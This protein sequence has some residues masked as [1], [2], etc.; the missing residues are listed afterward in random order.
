MALQLLQTSE[1]GGPAQ[2][3]AHTSPSYCPHSY[4]HHTVTVAGDWGTLSKAQEK[5]PKKPN[6]SKEQ[7]TL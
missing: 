6:Q 3:I 4:C 2:V 1:Q 7:P 5:K